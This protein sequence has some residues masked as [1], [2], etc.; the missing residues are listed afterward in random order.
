MSKKIKQLFSGANTYI[1]VAE[2]ISG[3][4]WWID[5]SGNNWWNR[6][7]HFR[8]NAIYLPK[9]GEF[10]LKID[11]TWYHVAPGNLVYI[12]AGSDLEYNFDGNGPLEKYYVHFDLTFGKNQLLDYFK[13]PC[14]IPLKN[15]E[16][17]E[18]I[19][20]GLLHQ[21]SNLD[22]PIS[23]IASNGLL[24]SLIAEMLS[25]SNAQFIHSPKNLDKEMSDTI[26]YIENHFSEPLSI[27]DLAERVGYSV[28]YFT[29]K[30]KKSFGCTPTDYIA[31]IKVSYAKSWLRTGTMSITDIASSLGFCDASYF[32]N[33]FKAKT[34]LCPGYYRKTEK[35]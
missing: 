24:F 34:G 20:N 26:D 18:N 28:T 16:T 10:N 33:F 35:D 11:H 3:N 29:K 1:Y 25:Q 5:E 21:A 19:F 22:S 8:Y 23:Q 9:I 6:K 31:N 30:F 32:S 4:K 15:E 7:T 13:T 2:Y 14:L 17:V 12:P 27:S